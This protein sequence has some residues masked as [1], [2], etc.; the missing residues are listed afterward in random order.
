M[1]GNSHKKSGTPNQDC[2]SVKLINDDWVIAVVA[3]GLG[4]AT[5]SNLGSTT[6]V[7][8]VI[9]FFD[10]SCPNFWYVDNIVATIRLAFVQAIQNIKQLAKSQNVDYQEFETTL[11]CAVYNNTKL[12]YGHIGDGGIITLDP[13][14]CYHQLT[15]PQK[16]EHF[17]ETA[18]LTEN[19]KEWSFGVSS[20]PVVALLLVTDGIYDILCP[21]LISS[22]QNPIW[23]NQVKLFLDCGLLELNSMEDFNEFEYQLP[24]ILSEKNFASVSD[25]KTMIGIINTSIIPERMPSEYYKEPDWDSLKAKMREGLYGDDCALTAL[26]EI[27][28]QVND[29]T[30]SMGDS[31][32]DI[33]RFDSSK[34]ESEG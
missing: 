15:M 26:T 5:H 31:D 21:S 30:K 10:N 13:F 22:T 8:S 23:I 27:S 14:G 32:E 6:A 4:S 24:Q 9:D 11:T 34:N 17:N 2:K 16:G 18:V 19:P 3:D 7:K 29:S 20:E 33:V 25:D 12:V 1:Q 28:E